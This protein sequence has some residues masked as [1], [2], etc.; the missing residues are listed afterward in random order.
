MFI[1]I[2]MNSTLQRNH[3]VKTFQKL[4]EQGY[5]ESWSIGITDGRISSRFR[6]FTG[7]EDTLTSEDKRDKDYPSLIYAHLGRALEL[8]TGEKLFKEK[9]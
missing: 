2:K 1:K 3:H 8:I 4:K 7:T 9:N 5:L 6:T